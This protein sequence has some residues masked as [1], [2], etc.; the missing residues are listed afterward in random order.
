MSITVIG[1][2]K[3]RS[4][5]RDAVTQLTG[6]GFYRNDI[7]LS[8]SRSSTTDSSNALSRNDGST[9]QGTGDAGTPG[10]AYEVVETYSNGE[11]TYSENQP[12]EKKY[13]EH[14]GNAIT[15]FFDSLFGDGSDDAKKYSTASESADSIVTVH[16]GT[17]EQAEEAANILDACGAMDIDEGLLV[18]ET[19]R[20]SVGE[21]RKSGNLYPNAMDGAR[22]NTTLNEDVNTRNEE[23]T[24]KRLRDEP[25]TKSRRRSEEISGSNLNE[26]TNVGLTEAEL[27]EAGLSSEEISSIKS[28][29]PAD[30]PPG[31]RFNEGSRQRSRSRIFE[32][33]VDEDVRLREEHDRIHREG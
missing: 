4:E 26:V 27:A 33:K 19:Y 2:F 22:E 1:F 3:T 15:R 7:D 6:A 24:D 9:D 8:D 13:E 23:W 25:L 29:S 32:A 30:L 31:N 17:R 16:A 12:S 5:A 11:V 18:K 14:K 10:P 20:D 28:D 21:N